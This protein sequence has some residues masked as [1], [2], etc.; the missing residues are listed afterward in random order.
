VGRRRGAVF[1]A[2]VVIALVGGHVSW[3]TA[4]AAADTPAMAAGATLTSDDP[5]ARGKCLDVEGVYGPNLIMWPCHGAANQNFTI[6]D[7]VG[8]VEI[9][10]VHPD[11]R[12][13]CVDGYR[14]PYQQLMW[15]ECD[16]S[17]EQRWIRHGTRNRMVLENVRYPGQCIDIYD[18]GRGT[19]VQLWDCHSGSNQLWYW[20]TPP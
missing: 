7:R 20:P 15:Y 8:Y 13:M 17:L 1:T 6:G 12:Y 3:S 4:P 5:D 9:F 10:T 11:G 18:W 16:E 19:A 14:G 2:V